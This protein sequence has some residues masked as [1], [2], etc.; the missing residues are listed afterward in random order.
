MTIA[1]PCAAASRTTVRRPLRSDAG[2]QAQSTTTAIWG[3]TCVALRRGSVTHSRPAPA[4][5]RLQTFQATMAWQACTAPYEFWGQ[6]QVCGFLTTHSI[7]AMAASG[8]CS[9]VTGRSDPGSP[10]RGGPQAHELVRAAALLQSTVAV[11]RRRSVGYSATTWPTR[12]QKR[13]ERCEY[14]WVQQKPGVS[15]GYRGV[16]T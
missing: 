11:S 14:C 1:V 4:T 15:K 9:N 7:R 12:A 13:S 6:A 5:L 2:R 16:V 10:R 3:S 8:C